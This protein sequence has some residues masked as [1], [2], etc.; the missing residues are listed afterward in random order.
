MTTDKNRYV[1]GLFG[2]VE[3]VD[4][5]TIWRDG[6]VREL[7]FRMSNRDVS[8]TP[9]EMMAILRPGRDNLDKSYSMIADLALRRVFLRGY[10]LRCPACDLT[11]WYEVPEISES[12]ACSGCLTRLQPPLDAQFHYRLN[13]L[14]ARGLD[15]GTMSVVLTLLFFKA[16]SSLSFLYV[17]GVEVRQTRRMDIDIIGS[18]DGHLFIT[19]C[20]DL[21]QGISKHAVVEVLA[22]LTDLVELATKVGAEM[23]FLSILRPD[24]PEELERK[25]NQLKKK[26][27]NSVAIHV[28]A[29]NALERGRI[30]KRITMGGRL[31]SQKEHIVPST[32]FDFLPRIRAR[33]KGW[34]KRKGERGISF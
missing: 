7:F 12:M 5:M 33:K 26:H 23:V 14:V 16:L 2:L 25:I 9:Q 34:S 8:Y 10:K 3:S 31:A 15:Q 28:L 24:V 19:E 17:P 20:K 13:Q 18:C 11:G 1:R 30:E 32:V 21:R 27:Q 29:L 22:Q 4:Q 6:G